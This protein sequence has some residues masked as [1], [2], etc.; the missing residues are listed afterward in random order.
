M[1]AKAISA[2]IG[3]C[4]GWEGEREGG[5]EGGRGKILLP[6]AMLTGFGRRAVPRRAGSG[7]SLEEAVSRSMGCGV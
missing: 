6:R 1:L 5:R 3:G 7:V 2:G 4:G